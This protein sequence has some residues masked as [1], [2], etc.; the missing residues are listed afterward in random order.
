MFRSN[1][2]A[3]QGNTPNPMT[4]IYLVRHATPD[5]DRKDIPYDIH[6]GPPLSPKG[7]HEAE[8]VADF[9]K[10]QGVVK[11]YYSPFER[12]TTTA[13]I[14]ANRNQIPAFEE[15]RLAEWREAAENKESV[16]ERMW[17]IFDEIVRESAVVGPVALVS[18]GGPIT[19]LLL[20]LGM[21][22]ETL[23]V[24]K[25]KFDGF[26]PLPPAGAWLAERNTDATAWNLDLMFTP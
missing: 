24:W 5:W 9:L 17:S 25:Q 2:S 1:N 22:E 26:N 7:R 10:E 23:S 21:R 16:R 13:Q 18:H 11:L 15:T 12:S 19:F 8:A 3:S 14:I 6:P 20:S 4:K